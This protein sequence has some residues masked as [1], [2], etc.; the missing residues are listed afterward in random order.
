MLLS[1][2]IA[3]LSFAGKDLPQDSIHLSSTNDLLI[4]M[5]VLMWEGFSVIQTR[6]YSLVG[7]KLAPSL[8]FI[9][10]MLTMTPSDESHGFSENLR[11]SDSYPLIECSFLLR[12]CRA[13][14]VRSV[15]M[16]RYSLL[17]YWYTVFYEAYRLGHPVMRPLFVEYPLD[18]K[19]YALDDQWMVGSSIL[20]KPV[21][22]QGATHAQV[23]FPGDQPW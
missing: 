13:S 19:T 1:I 15:A 2:N 21:T 8:H 7:I 11:K 10:A 4:V 17:P 20:V 5:Q 14:N 6:N 16:L 3:G 12:I 23:Y 9:A 22:E 18:E